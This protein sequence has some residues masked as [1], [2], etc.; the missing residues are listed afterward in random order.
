MNPKANNERPGSLKLSETIK[1]WAKKPS[2]DLFKN[3]IFKMC[4]GIIYTYKKN[5]AL[6][7]LNGRYPTKPKYL[8]AHAE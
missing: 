5:L 6:N 4:L 7:D 1:L 2:S 3:I 8:K